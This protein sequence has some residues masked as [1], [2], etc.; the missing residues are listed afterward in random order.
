[1]PEAGLRRYVASRAGI[2]EDDDFGLLWLTGDDLPGAVTLVDPYD[3]PLPP[4][5][6][7]PEHKPRTSDLLR[8][9]LAGVQL[10]FSAL[11]NATG[12]LT[13]RANGREGNRII[14]LPA[15]HFDQVPEN[16]CATSR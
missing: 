12:G 16:E 2:A 9:S 15:T 7:R 8:F 1:M 14:K 10:K 3:R 11:E 13:I 5:A 4:A 6:E